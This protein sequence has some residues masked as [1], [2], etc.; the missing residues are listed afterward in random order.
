MTLDNDITQQA[1]GLLEIG[2]KRMVNTYPF[3]ASFISRWEI[4][5]SSLVETI[6]ITLRGASI[7]LLF[8]SKFIVKC[9]LAE[10][11]GL[12]HH[13]VNHLLFEHLLIDPEKFENKEALIIAEEVTVNEWVKEPLP[14]NPLLLESFPQLIENEDTFT[15]YKRLSS[16]KKIKQSK[17]SN[18]QKS[19]KD[20]LNSSVFVPNFKPSVPNLSQSV[21]K[22]GKNVRNLNPIKPLDDHNIWEEV[23][24]AGLLGAMTIKVI[25]KEAV[26]KLSSQQLSKVPYKTREAINAM[27]GE[28]TN[29]LFE[30]VNS[31]NNNNSRIDWQ[32]LLHKYVREAVETYPSFT[33]VPRRFP[34]LLGIVPSWQ[35]RPSKA[36]VMV[37]IDTSGSI[38]LEVLDLIAKEIEIISHCHQVTIVECD[39]QI[40][41]IYP[42]IGKIGNVIGRGGTDLRPP[43]APS[44]ISTI[45]PHVI[46]YFTD[47]YGLAPELPPHIPVIWGITENGQKPTFWGR[48]VSVSRT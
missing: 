25:A 6:G 21:L 29:C 36:V 23:R 46:C 13:E 10:I 24:N 45:R 37:V 17:L 47:G 3:H 32:E 31:E 1:R 40:Q 41:R 5:P 35:Y 11:I 14:G 27:C 4:Y 19:R 9:S 48:E 15:R 8:N 2:Q 22:K 34:E 38:S 30:E 43:F 26:E 42:F 7:L 12:L 16:S 33:K 44:V 20:V 28:G 18:E 39:C